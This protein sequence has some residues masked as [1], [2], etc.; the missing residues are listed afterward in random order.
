MDPAGAE[1]THVEDVGFSGGP[2][3]DLPED[4]RALAKTGMLSG[5][6][7]IW[8]GRPIRVPGGNAGLWWS[9]GLFLGS[10]A[11][12]SLFVGLALAMRANHR[13]LVEA[14]ETAAG[15]AIVF[16]IV[17]GVTVVDFSRDRRAAWRRTRSTSYALTDR[18]AICWQA[19]PST[20]GVMVFTIPERSIGSVHRVEYPDGSGDVVFGGNLP[21]WEF[22]GLLGVPDVR[23]LKSLAGMVLLDPDHRHDPDPDK[24]EAH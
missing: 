11:F 6:R 16:V 13:P 4:L 12:A 7:L 14:F 19:Q 5:E 23:C 10:A 22:R 24:I 21:H 20:R 17:T 8:A 9:L 15:I 1:T 2:S 3:R 18:K